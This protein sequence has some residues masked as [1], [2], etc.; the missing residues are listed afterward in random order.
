MEVALPHGATVEELLPRLAEI[1]MRRMPDAVEVRGVSLA[2]IGEPPFPRS[3]SVAELGMSEGDVLELRGVSVASAEQ[4]DPVIGA[5][6]AEQ[7]VMTWTPAAP[8]APTRPA[9]LDRTMRQLPPRHS[10]G[11]RVRVALGASRGAAPAPSEVA[12]VAPERPRPADLSR[13]ST[14]TLPD[15]VRHA[16]RSSEYLNLLDQ[17]IAAPRLRQCVTIAVLS[18]KGGV[19]KTTIT[20][21]LGQLLAMIR[22]DRVVAVDTNPDF[23]SLGRSLSP[24]HNVFVDD[25]VPYLEHPALTVTTLDACL[26]RTPHG[27][28]VLPAPTDPERMARLDDVA[29]TRV[30][31]RLK[32]LVGLV[33]LD[34]GTG[35]W[36]PV[37]RAAITA[38]DQ[39]VVVTDDAPATASLVLEACGLLIGSGP[40]V[41]LVVNRMRSSSRLGVEAVAA[42]VPEAAGLIV[43][44]EE[45]AAA[46][47]VANGEFDWDE[48]PATW[49]RHVREL[50]ALLVG[51]WPELGVTG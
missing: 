22:A 28:M 39:I 24:Q 44:P 36:D 51:A 43:I 7:P 25:I 21:L 33:I 16:W 32:S 15:R 46:V 12:E 30:I 41:T 40:P 38:A 47:R 5:P 6:T 18:P 1:C 31:G 37:T 19:G 50:A 49:H 48:A 17:A 9:V 20:V 10:L 45:E 23:G 26:A 8:M 42:H 35:L 14:P 3:A 29:Y 4:P 11:G 27:L 34:C 13:K 2:R